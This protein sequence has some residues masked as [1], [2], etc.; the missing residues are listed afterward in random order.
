MGKAARAGSISD[1]TPVT[2]A[3]VDE[4]LRFAALHSQAGSLAS[5]RELCRRALDRQPG[6]PA[7]LHELALIELRLG[8]YESALDLAC[9]GTRVKPSDYRF[10]AIAGRAAKAL[11]RF[12][13]ASRFYR[14][15]IRLAPTNAD[16]H[17]SLGITMRV[18][19]RIP[20]AIKHYESAI[21]LAP[22]LVAA[23]H[24]LANAWFVEGRME[25][26]ERTYLRV[27]ELDPGFGEAQFELGNIARRRR[28]RD[29]ALERYRSALQAGLNSAMNF[30]RLGNG[31]TAL[32]DLESAAASFLRATELEPRNVNARFALGGALYD[33]RRYDEAVACFAQA[34]AINPDSAEALVNLGAVLRGRGR[35][36]EAIACFER[37]IARAPE[38]AEA[39]LNLGIALADFHDL[40]NAKRS[41]E[42][43]IALAPKSDEALVAL[44]MIARKGLDFGQAMKLCGLALERGPNLPQV[45]MDL[46]AVHVEA[47][48]V[49]QGIECYRTAAHTPALRQDALASIAMA[50][51]YVE[52]DP[53][54][55]LQAQRDFGAH[56]A[57]PLLPAM[58][59]TPGG[60]RPDRLRVGYVSPDFRRHAV[61][62]FFEPLLAHRDRDRFEAVCYFNHPGPDE[63]TQ[64]LRS[65]ADDWRDC[66]RWSDEELAAR[67]RE[68][69]IDVL[70]DLAGHTS[71]NRLL[72]FA[73]RPA[74]VQVTW[75]GYPGSTGLSAID[76]RISDW[77]VDP[78]GAEAFNAENVLRMPHSY[79]CFQP[80]TEVSDAKPL[81][82][83]NAAGLTFGS[84]NNAA[85]IGAATLDLWSEVLRAVPASRLVLKHKAFGDAEVR[86]RFLTRF[87]E[88][89][90]DAGRLAMSG[91]MREQTDHLAAY[92]EVDV[93]LDTFPYNGATT[94]C[95]ALWMGVPV[96]S[97]SGR[98]HASR[99]G[100]SILAAAGL[101]AF[102]AKSK[103]QFVQIAHGL[104]DRAN[105]AE[106]RGQ[107]RERLR[108]SAL[109]DAGRFA[110]DFERCL[111]QA[112][113][114]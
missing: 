21:A 97:L 64:R 70:V 65:M 56:A 4:M 2:G 69:G 48:E 108:Q 85:K 68:D 28:R 75:L 87:V 10:Y 22:A 79:F 76:H 6:H 81:P 15:A 43:A 47:G 105:L 54:T 98:T 66:V 55:V 29:E 38:L 17:V 104:S 7:G 114:H 32:D 83:S 106:L 80:P 78:E 84:F 59:R 46:G 60:A 82:A 62:S 88:R 102:C 41:V 67:I 77:Q 99:M 33:L 8:E 36:E 71:W 50:A 96:V 27:L 86:E 103:D 42:R 11:S 5:A 12:E 58:A 44:A 49:A 35:R 51:H 94:T 111:D 25:E 112:W 14:R 92:R 19:G 34:L 30:V 90:V 39:H 93:A 24:N 57:R 31:L 89:G 72:V 45:Y 37:A 23:H 40:D 113:S 52:T 73:R 9:E 109:T 100:R 101:H 63:V 26:A 53:A 3:G 18:Q 20:E 95:E 13:E 110:R 107:L 1:R 16:L 61:A 91:W 74:P